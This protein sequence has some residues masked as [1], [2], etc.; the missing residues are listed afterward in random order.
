MPSSLN[1]DNGVVS[2]TAGLKSSADSSGV[3]DLQTNG[4]TAISISASQVVSFANQPTYTGGTANGVMFL[5]GSKAVTTGTALTFD[6]SQLDI[7]LGSAGTPS[8]STPTDPN[9]GMFFPAA[10]T[11]AFAEGGVEA[12]RLDSS[13]N[14][15][16]GVTPSAWTAAYRAFDFGGYGNLF[17]NS[18]DKEVALAYNAAVISG[19]GW[20]YKN[21]NQASLYNQQNGKHIWQTAASGTAG[22]SISWTTP[23]TL[24]ASGNL[25]VGTTSP[26]SYAKAAFVNASG[27]ALYAGGG[28]Q[29]VFITGD[30]STRYV[31]YNASGNF[32]GGHIWQNGNVEFARIDLS[33]N[34]GIG[35]NSPSAKFEV[36]G[37][38]GNQAPFV[39]FTAT[40]A[41]ATFNWVSTALASNLAASN[42]LVHFIGQAASTNNAAWFGYKHAGAGSASNILTMGL[43]GVDNVLNVNGN[44]NVSLYGANTSA[45]GVGI[46]FPSTQSA[47]SDANCLDD[48]EEGTWTPVITGSGGGT[49]TYNHNSGVY[50]KVGSMVYIQF[51]VNVA[52]RS[53]G[54]GEI[55]IDG[56]PFTSIS[57]GGYQEPA[58]ALQSGGWTTP[59]YAGA[60]YGFVMN[61][62]A[63]MR[64]RTQNNSDTPGEFTSIQAGTYFNCIMVY[65]AA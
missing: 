59:A 45:N 15:G 14:M 39:R 24:D 3:L 19:T 37:T 7:P 46:T 42:N 29:G 50:R 21:T 12:M 47:S 43:F 33:G 36:A 4:T 11:I 61:S 25:G 28:T 56:L 40:S 57:R 49:L 17:S 31:T 62:M 41:N 8:L 22:T 55:L 20:T 63:Q 44:A 52:S 35:T 5:N 16:L 51:G 1:A 30:N 2:G 34:F 65:C 38:A 53:G 60:M 54:G 13:G 18:T 64:T 48:Y 9:T 32:A 27:T 23:M 6:G 58:N 10:D 26:A